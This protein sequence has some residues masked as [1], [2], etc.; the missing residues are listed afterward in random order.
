MTAVIDPSKGMTAI[1]LTLELDAADA[2]F[3]VPTPAAGG[4]RSLWCALLVHGR[5]LAGNPTTAMLRVD[6]QALGQLHALVEHT[7]RESDLH[8]PEF[9]AAYAHAY[10]ERADE[11]RTQAGAR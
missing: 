6:A 1:D 11:L 3:A 7:A 8:A 2:A 10:I 4:T 5:D 9:A